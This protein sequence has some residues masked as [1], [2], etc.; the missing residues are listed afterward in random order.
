M[1]DILT[2]IGSGAVGLTI[3]YAYYELITWRKK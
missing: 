2:Y 1:L 3:T